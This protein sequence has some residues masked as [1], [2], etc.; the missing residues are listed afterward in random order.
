MWQ[1]SSSNYGTLHVDPKPIIIAERYKFH[2][3]EQEDSETIRQ[4]LAKLQKLAETCEFGLYREEAIRDRFVCGLR[5]QSIQRKLLA[6]ATLTLQ[7]AL[8]KACASELTEKE[9]SGF[10]GSAYDVKKVEGSFPECFSGHQLDTGA[11]VRII[12]SHVWSG[13]L[14][15]KSLRQTDVRLKSYSGHEIPVLKEAKVQVS[16]GD[17]QACLPVIVTAGDGPALMGRNWLSVLRLDWKQIKQISLEPCDRGESLVSKYASLFDGGLGTIKGVTAH[18]KLKEN[19]TPQFFKPRPVPFALKEKIAEELKRLEGIGVLQKVEFSDWATPIV[20]VLKPDGT[21]RICGDYKVTINP[22]LDVPEYPMPTAEELFT[23]LNGGQSFSKLDLSSAYQQVLLDE[24]SRP[25]TLLLGPKRGIPVL[26]A[27]RLQ[28]WAIQL[29][30]YQYDIEYRASK[31]HAN[32]DALSRLPRKTVEEPDDW[33]IEADQVNRVQMQRAPIT[34]SQIREATRGDPVLSRVMHCILHG[35]SAEKCISDEFKIYYNKQDEFTVEDGCILRG[36]RAVIPAKYQAAVLSELHL[37]HPGMVRMKSLARLHVWWPS[38]DHDA[39][40]TVRDCHACQANRCK[41]PEKVSSPW[42]WPTRPWQ[43]IHVDFAG[44]FNGQMFLIVV[45]AKSKWIEVFPMSSTTASTTIRALRFL[46]ATHGLPEVIISHNGP[47]FV[48]Q[49]MKDFLK[50]NGIRHCLSAPYHPASNGETERA[51]RT[52]KESIKTMKDEPGTQADKLARLLLSYRTTPHTATGC[53]PAE[54]LMGRRIRTRLDALHPDLSAG[55]SEKT[56]LGNHT[57]RR[58]FLPG[59]PVMVRDYRDRKRP[60]IKGVVQDRVGPVTYHVM[61]TG[62]GITDFTYWEEPKEVTGKKIEFTRVPFYI[63]GY[64]FFDC[65]HGKDR[66]AALKGK[67]QQQ[68]DEDG[69]FILKKDRFLA[70][71]SKK[72]NCPARNVCLVPNNAVSNECDDV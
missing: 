52:F 3:A 12:L 31:D 24:E 18:L 51:V 8:E 56:K 26:A 61:I 30:A 47:Q 71:P 11:S 68:R 7:T 6:E 38:L 17:Q 63:M 49:E 53:T 15:A 69:D 45:D 40:Q 2:K 25:L 50:S 72:A 58:N 44:P 20:P 54:I 16:Y 19:A 46:F 41:S 36:T 55:M 48:A 29:S 14:A 9:A 35:W 60:W 37:N 33:N 67:Q 64:N 66:N 23:Q 28:S 10:H 42:I 70:Q 39:E 34:V 22:T 32:A 57:T 43:R 65:Q 62:R 59:D 4:Y 13:V 1:A 5:S 21:V 27:S